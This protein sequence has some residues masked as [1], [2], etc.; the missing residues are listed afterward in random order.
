MSFEC[1]VVLF[2]ALMRCYTKEFD[3]FFSPPNLQICMNKLRVKTFAHFCLNFYLNIILEKFPTSTPSENLP[4]FIKVLNL[5][6]QYHLH[7]LSSIVKSTHLNTSFF[8]CLSFPFKTFIFSFKPSIKTLFICMA[9]N[10]VGTR[11]WHN[12]LKIW[13]ITY[14]HILQPLQPLSID[15]KMQTKKENG[16]VTIILP[17]EERANHLSLALSMLL[18]CIW[19]G[20]VLLKQAVRL[21]WLMNFS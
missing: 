8:H 11:I 17:L 13:V 14:K 20:W 1:I 19:L 18:E 2:I 3:F 5:A 10:Q 9:W 21:K 7:K 12:V 16:I 15:W 4:P 6:N